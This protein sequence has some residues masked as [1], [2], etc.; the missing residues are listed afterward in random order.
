MKIIV[1]IYSFLLFKLLDNLRTTITKVKLCNDIS[2]HDD[3]YRFLN[4]ICQYYCVKNLSEDI[5]IRF[6]EKAEGKSKAHN[7]ANS[8]YKGRR[9]EDYLIKTSF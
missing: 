7:I 4:K 3:V 1:I 9:K 8:V 5:K 6:K 2:P